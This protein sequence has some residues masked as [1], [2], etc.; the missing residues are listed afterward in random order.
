[1]GIWQFYLQV[2]CAR[3]RLCSFCYG[4]MRSEK[5]IQFPILKFP[6]LNV[7]SYRFFIPAISMKSKSACQH[8]QPS[9][10]ALTANIAEILRRLDILLDAGPKDRLRLSSPPAP[11]P[12]REKNSPRR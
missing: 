12:P 11:A 7:G 8:G 1:M 10:G 2:T 9:N 5:L 4:T 6:V 3:G